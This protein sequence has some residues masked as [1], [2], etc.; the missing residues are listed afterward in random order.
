MS[1][2]IF[3]L[4]K[5][6]FSVLQAT[7]FLIFLFT[8]SIVFLV[9]A[10]NF[11]RF[12]QNDTLLRKNTELESYNLTPVESH[13]EGPTIQISDSGTPPPNFTGQ[14]V[15]AED[16]DSERILY[17][18]NANLRLSPASTTKLM[19]AI[20][21]VDHFQ[22]GDILTVYP[23]DIVDGSSMGLN[24]GDRFSFR[25]LLY[26]M[27]L[28]SGNDA[29]FTI[30]SNYPGG[31]NMFILQMNKKAKELGLGDT[32]FQNPAGFDA[33]SQY[34]SAYDLAKI[35]KAAIASPQIAK[36]VATRETSIAS[37]D[38]SKL[39][40]LRNLNQL[41]GEQGVLGIK[42]GTTELAGEN[43]VGLVDRNN[44][45]ILTVVLKS[46]DRFGETRSL[47]NWAYNNFEWKYIN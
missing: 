44:H 38:N 18:K 16:L 35:A 25:S 31:L 33:P 22:S 29:A 8:L 2:R 13:L 20:V 11:I 1:R 39:Y 6:H 17:E 47:I 30:A 36:I 37:S 15:L 21:A 10:P 7:I 27:L 23:E 5:K 45:K 24:A 19:S 28:N 46:E 14:A 41:L 43:F 42:T 9:A 32:N 4:N 3:T 40:E 12:A 34:S 26:G